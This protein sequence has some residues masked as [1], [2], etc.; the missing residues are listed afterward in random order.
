MSLEQLKEI[1]QKRM[2]RQAIEVGRCK[3]VMLKSEQ[4]IE[5]KKQ[6]LDYYVNWRVDNQ[7]K[8]FD[9]LQSAVFSPQDIQKYMDQQEH[10]KDEEKK[11]QEELKQAEAELEVTRQKYREA[12]INLA[13]ITKKLEKINEMIKE[14][15]RLLVEEEKRAEES[16]NDEIASLSYKG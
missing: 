13:E 5:Q 10:M 6:E 7:E 9:N 3:D 8:M 11:H 12:R 2:E 15:K 14:D 4:D 1:R 16:Q